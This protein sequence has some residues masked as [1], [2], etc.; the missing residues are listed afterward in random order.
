MRP[1]LDTA[2]FLS[3]YLMFVL[4]IMIIILPLTD[5]PGDDHA[6]PVNDNRLLPPELPYRFGN[7][8]KGAAIKGST[9]AANRGASF[10][11]RLYLYQ[12][13]AVFTSVGACLSV[14]R[15]RKGVGPGN[16]FAFAL[17]RC[18]GLIGHPIALLLA[19]AAPSDPPNRHQSHDFRL[20]HHTFSSFIRNGTKHLQAGVSV[21]IPSSGPCPISQK[22]NQI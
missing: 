13:Y 9:A 1:S 5:K 4:S 12:P 17:G 11:L 10:G 14:A 3:I 15:C 21:V 18:N 6:V 16:Q 2:Y 20:F 8:L 7:V 19:S 22:W